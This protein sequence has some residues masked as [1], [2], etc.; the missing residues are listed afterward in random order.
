MD[1]C[2]PDKLGLS[3]SSICTCTKRKLHCSAALP[4]RSRWICIPTTAPAVRYVS[5]FSV[6]LGGFSFL[7][8]CYLHVCKTRLF[9]FF[10]ILVF[11]LITCCYSFFYVLPSLSL[12]LFLPLFLPHTRIHCA[13]AALVSEGWAFPPCCEYEASLTSPPAYPAPS[14]PLSSLPLSSSPIVSLVSS[15]LSD[16]VHKTTS[17]QASLKVAQ[18]NK[19]KQHNQQVSSPSSVSNIAH[20]KS[21]QIH[22][23]IDTDLFQYYCSYYTL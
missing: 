11:F 6:S 9:L 16:N 23:R 3:H 15:Y 13:T 17:A 10:F 4:A 14:L 22:T 1:R 18:Y 7:F 20:Y 12:S 19:H 5:A 2:Y 8:F 21:N